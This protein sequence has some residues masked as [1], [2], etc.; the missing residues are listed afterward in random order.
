MI[1]IYHNPRCCKSRTACSFANEN[2]VKFEVY[3][4]LKEGLNKVQITDILKKANLQALDIIRQTETVF[5]ENY[6]G[7]DLNNAK[8]I[9]AI[10]DHPILLQRPIVVGSNYAMVLR[11]EEALE[12]F[13]TQLQ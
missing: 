13:L 9:Q 1:I 8:W 3:E 10:I 12:L 2:K 7:K 6:K 5:K 4:Y 11:S